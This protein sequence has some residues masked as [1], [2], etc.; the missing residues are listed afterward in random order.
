MIF[1]KSWHLNIHWKSNEIVFLPYHEHN[2]GFVEFTFS[3]MMSKIFMEDLNRFSA[4]E[5]FW[6]T[7]IQVFLILCH[8]CMLPIT[9][10]HFNLRNAHLF[11]IEKMKVSFIA[12]LHGVMHKKII[13]CS[14]K[15]F[16]FF[17]RNSWIKVFSSVFKLILIE[18]IMFWK[19]LI[20]KL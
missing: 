11:I 4:F 7:L 2:V 9:Y 13:L 16:F 18:N 1:E 17:F 15:D 14:D 12:C 3:Q 6:Y 20:I 19:K 8:F 10:S 5:L